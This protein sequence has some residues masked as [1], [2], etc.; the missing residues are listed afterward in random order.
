MLTFGT[1]PQAPHP[2]HRTCVTPGTVKHEIGLFLAPRTASV[3]Q[4]VTH[5]PLNPLRPRVG[6]VPRRQHTRTS[7]PTPTQDTA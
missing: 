3:L 7:S 2:T 4:K 1:T 5:A 6:V